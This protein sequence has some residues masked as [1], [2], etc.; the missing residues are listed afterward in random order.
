MA[1]KKKTETGEVTEKKE[2]VK[3]KMERLEKELGEIDFATDLDAYKKKADELGAAAAV[4]YNQKVKVKLPRARGNEERY[5]VVNWNDYRCTIERGKE[6]EV[7]RGVAAILEQSERQQELADD[8]MYGL[9]EDYERE[10]A[11]LNI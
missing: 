3:A 11:S 5:V 6:V 2:S 9:Q 7:P 1:T 10:A 8:Y 4:Y